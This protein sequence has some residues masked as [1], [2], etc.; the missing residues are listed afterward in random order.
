MSVASRLGGHGLGAE[1][2]AIIRAVGLVVAGVTLFAVIDALGKLLSERQSVVQI[3]W[4]RYAFALPVILAAVPYRSW[5]S[6]ARVGRPGLQIARAMMPVLASFSVVVG[7]GLL[8]LAEV[9]ALTF[10]SPLVVVALSAPLLGERATIHD[11]IGVALGFLGIL[12]IVRPG[13]SAMAWAAIFPLGCAFFFALFQLTTR[14][15]GR[16]DAPGAT[17]AWSLVAGTLATTPFLLLD[18]R[19]V[20]ATGWALMALSGLCFG[21]TQYL[22]IQA[23]RLAPAAILTPFTYAQI[24]PAV[25]FGYL[26]FGTVPDAWAAFGTVIIIA[27]GLYVLRRHSR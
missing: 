20:D 12:V 25:A 22:L 23:F 3:V 8:P 6:L 24:I 10:A 18:W 15:V 4:A 21:G 2:R 7:L 19:P 13:A 17:L 9:T 14:L 11:W 1:R 27:A 16:S 5:S 26:L